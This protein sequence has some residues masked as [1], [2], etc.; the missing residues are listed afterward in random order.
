LMMYLTL[1]VIP[2]LLLLRAP[3]RTD[4]PVDTHAVMD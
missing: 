1:A 2:L 3:R 4:A